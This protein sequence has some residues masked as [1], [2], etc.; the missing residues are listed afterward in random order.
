MDPG[1]IDLASDLPL[2]TSADSYAMSLTASP[3][4]ISTPTTS[5]TVTYSIDDI[6]D[7]MGSSG[8]YFGIT[9]LS[10][11]PNVPG[12]LDLTSMG[13]PG[14]FY[15]LDALGVLAVLRMMVLAWFTPSANSAS[16]T[17]GPKVVF[18]QTCSAGRSW[19]FEVSCLSQA[20]SLHQ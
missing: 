13:M 19:F 12:G 6:P 15:Y 4:P 10:T 20:G 11:T 8:Q 14:C 5:T 3:D 16:P 9:I 2:T 17:S 1:S 18:C 7:A